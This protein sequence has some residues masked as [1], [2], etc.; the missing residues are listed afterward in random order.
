MIPVQ[1]KEHLVYFM[2]SGMMRLSKYD[3][4]F[5]QNLQILTLEKS[6][7]T[8]NQV[9]LF[10][11]LIEKYRRQLHKHG[12]NDEQIAQLKW[13][14]NIVP[15]DPK[16]TEAYVTVDSDKIFFKSPFSKKFVDSFNKI[17][18]NPFR[19]MKEK[20]VYEAPFSTH[21]LRVL[22][23]ASS[24]HYPIIN[25]CPITSQLLNN[26]EQF[27]AK[28][29]SPTLI[30]A[31]GNYL[32]A[33]TNKHVDEAIKDLPLTPS[34]SC[35]VKLATHGVR[36]DDGIINNDPLLKFASEY[37]TDVDFKDVDLLITYLNAMNC[38]A[39]FVVGQASM[40][41]QY[42][43]ILI[44]KLKEA[45]IHIDDRNEVLIEARLSDYK[46]PVKIN[47]SS[48]ITVHAST[49]K[50]IIRMKNSLPVVVK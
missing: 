48:N 11:K 20:K 45:N 27:N 2:Q 26:T 46:N 24:D 1:T 23:S 50:K 7:L 10:D 41:I 37:I 13:E 40:M 25:Y 35:L 21:A 16:F 4:R 33:A 31:N 32:I 15:S 38:D 34:V 9:A 42:R 12:L 14:A 6:N 49:L 39:V 29:W 3:L 30:N 44:S 17:T 22:L 18:N 5:V 8:T 19:W 43:R 47:L 28:H 36:I